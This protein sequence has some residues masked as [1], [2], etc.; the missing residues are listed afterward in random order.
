MQR[1][2]QQLYNAFLQYHQ[3][4][5][6]HNAS[7]ITSDHIAYAAITASHIGAAVIKGVHIDVAAIG[8]S[9]IKI[10]AISASHIELASIIGANIASGSITA[11]EIGD[12]TIRGVEIASATIQGSN[13][14]SGTILGANIATATI[15]GSNINNLAITAANIASLTITASQIASLTIIGGPG[16]NIAT[17]TITND[18]IVANT[19]TANEI[20][21]GTITGDRIAANTIAA[22]NIVAGTITAA[23]I[24]AGAINAT[25]IDVDR[26]SAIS[27]DI[28]TVTAGVIQSYNI[29]TDAGMYIDLDNAEIVIREPDGLI[30]DSDGGISVAAGGDIILTPDDSDPS[31]LR[32]DFGSGEYIDLSGNVTYESLSFYP[33]AE[34]TKRV[35]IG[36]TNGFTASP[37]DSILL[38]AGG[39]QC[40]SP[41]TDDVGFT[42]VAY[43]RV[44]NG[45][46]D[47]YITLQ[48]I[49]SANSALISI[50]QD[51]IKLS[52]STVTISADLYIDGKI[53]S[54]VGIGADPLSILTVQCASS[55][56]WQE[57]FSG[58]SAYTPYDHEVVIKNDENNITN[59]FAGIFFHA[60]ET[61]N[62]TEFNSARIAA[63]R[64]AG[65][66][67]ALAFS[68][69]TGA[70]MEQ[71]MLIDSDLDLNASN[72]ILKPNQSAFSA[73]CASAVTCTNDT[74]VTIDGTTERYDKASDFVAST[75]IYTATRTGTHHISWNI[76]IEDAL[77][78]CDYYALRLVTSNKTYNQVGY[79]NADELPVGGSDIHFNGDM[80]VDME[81]ADTA[82]LQVLQYNG[83]SSPATVRASNSFI[84]GVFC[85]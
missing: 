85:G 64:E 44:D 33:G 83:G 70:S 65:F 2:I 11:R 12:G 47:P 46:G 62:T 63:I 84:Q 14:A 8:A 40:A 38:A 30:I 56:T 77:K 15:E 66:D 37:F 73:Y 10:A 74:W 32:W 21:A 80:Y 25:H 49:Y 13:I 16:G 54:E 78:T 20:A 19:I 28:G 55:V 48:S 58:S 81:A 3:A 31:V 1:Q 76:V 9:H 34:H 42:K 57:T 45:D 61:T 7:S 5:G 18:N 43:V 27:A 82:Y 22:G 35:A 71:A 59:G 29:A 23:E 36:Y 52:A 17:S 68:V 41:C 4:A 6:N 53:T 26:L 79:R 69:R 67:T 72:F 51:T 60:G 75:G 39:I 50:H 24:A